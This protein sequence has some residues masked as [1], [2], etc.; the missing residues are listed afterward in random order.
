MRIWFCKKCNEWHEWS[1]LLLWW[2]KRYNSFHLWC[3]IQ[4]LKYDAEYRNKNREKRREY[5]RNYRKI[6]REE[7]S[8]YKRNYRAKKSNSEGSFVEA[9]FQYLLYQYNNKC[10]KCG[11]K[12]DIERDHIVALNNGGDNTI[13]NIQPL[14]KSCNSSKST[15]TEDYRPF[16]PL[17]I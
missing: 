3:H 6:N 2:D 13:K 17:F 15:K 14:C 4:K 10:L 12:I 16:I 9:E 5:N 8:E 1:D 11:N 7:I